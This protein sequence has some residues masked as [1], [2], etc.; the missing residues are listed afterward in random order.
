MV[1]Y[2]KDKG[3]V[4]RIDTTTNASLLTHKMSDELIEGGL[5]RI[6]ISIEGMNQKQYV[7]FASFRINFEKLVEN[8]RYFYEN[9]KQCEVIVKINGDTLTEEDKQNFY[10]TFGNIADGV[11]IE[12]IMSCWPDFE[13]TGGLEANSDFGIYGQRI[14]D[15]KACPYI[16]YSFSIN[17]NGSASACFLDW[18]RKIIIGDVTTQTVKDIW[19]GEPL[20]NLQKIMLRKQRHKHPTCKNCGQMSHGMPDNIDKYSDTLLSKI[21]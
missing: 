9:K 20:K 4:E 17:S 10:D 5:T 8:V 11:S 19:L 12:H 1:K 18:E 2:A 7:D 15:V 16:F 13:F 6:N 14:Q 3:C 21:L